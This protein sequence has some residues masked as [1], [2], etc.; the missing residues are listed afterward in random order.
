MYNIIG[1]VGPIIMLLGLPFQTWKMWILQLSDN[2]FWLL[3][4]L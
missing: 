3:Y 2:Y 1:C 4:N